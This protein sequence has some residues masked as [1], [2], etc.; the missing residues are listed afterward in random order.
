[1]GKQQAAY[2][3]NN[4]HSY[5]I[6]SLALNHDGSELAAGDVQG[7][8]LR[9]NLNNN[10]EEIPEG[11]PLLGHTGAI[12]NLAFERQGNLASAS[13]DTTIIIWNSAGQKIQRLIDTKEVFALAFS[14]D[15][16]KLYTGNLLGTL[17]VWN[18]STGKLEKTHSQQTQKISSVDVSDNN[19][20]VTG[21]NDL[22]IV[23]WNLL[24]D[25]KRFPENH[26][27]YIN[28]VNISSDGKIVVSFDSQEIKVFLIKS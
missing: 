21:S 20:I 1:M 14:P 18:V 25:F 22:S 13:N 17:R 28:G 12:N 19:I 15:G 7:A 24:G 23:A 8:L 9:W 2:T 3:F 16:K 26:D 11:I 6:L 27:N 4:N 5:R 10:S